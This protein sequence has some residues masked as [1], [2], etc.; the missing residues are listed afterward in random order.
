MTTP[1]SYDIARRIT[2]RFRKL[3]SGYT[4]GSFSNDLGTAF[5]NFAASDGR[6]YRAY[7]AMAADT[8]ARPIGFDHITG[9]R[10]AIDQLRLAEYSAKAV[11]AMA[12]VSREDAAVAEL[13]VWPKAGTAGFIVRPPAPHRLFLHSER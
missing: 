2:S 4:S 11:G 9:K 13:D 1:A 6:L 8:F 12:R 5:V 3:T 7:V 10:R